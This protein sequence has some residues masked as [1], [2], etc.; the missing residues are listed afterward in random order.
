M[1]QGLLERSG[2]TPRRRA[3]FASGGVLLLLLALWQL[4]GYWLDGHLRADLRA[5]VDL[6]AEARVA[7][8]ESVLRQ[9][10][11]LLDGLAA[12]TAHTPKDDRFKSA[13]EGFSSNLQRNDPVILAFSLIPREGRGYRWE[14][15]GAGLPAASP[16]PPPVPGLPT[17]GL[18]RLGSVLDAGAGRLVVEIILPIYDRDLF[19]GRATVLLALSPLLREAG[20]ETVDPE[21]EWALLK[22]PQRLLGGLSTLLERNPRYFSVNL[23]GSDWRL[24]VEPRDGWEAA[25]TTPLR[26]YGAGGLMLVVLLTVLFHLL[27]GRQAWLAESVHQSTEVLTR[28]SRNLQRETRGRLHLEEQLRLFRDLVD[29]SPDAF[30]IIEPAT[31]GVV[32][33]NRSGCRLFE[34]S[35]DLLVGAPFP[36]LVNLGGGTEGWSDLVTAV[37]TEP[38]KRLPGEIRLRD[39]SRRPVDIAL[40][41]VNRGS[42]RHL[43]A[44]VR[45]VSERTRTEQSLRENESRL[46]RIVEEMPVMLNAF[47]EQGR[48]LFWNRA[49]ERVS[50]YRAEEIVGNAEASA[51]LYPDPDYRRQMLAE[52]SRWG[53]NYRDREWRLTTRS[54]EVRH[55]LWSDI[56]AQVPIPGWPYWGVGVDITPLRHAEERLSLY[57]AIFSHSTDAVGIIA[58][59]G[60]YLRQN[61][62]HRRLLGYEDE[63][64]HRNTPALHMGERNFNDIIHDLEHKGDFRGEVTC[65]RADGRRIEVEISAFPVLDETGR[66]FCYVGIKRDATERRRVEQRL[67]QA[68]TVF[69][70]TT[71]GVMI[72]DARQRIIMVNDA[73]TSITGYSRREVLGRTPDLLGSGH[74][75]QSF[76]DA[77]NAQLREQGQWRGEIWNRRRDGELYPAW[78]SIGTVPND[79]GGISNFVAVFSDISSI[80]ESERKFA[81]LAHHDALTGLPNRLL[82]HA[83]LE[84]AINEARRKGGRLAVFFMDLDRFKAINDT[85]GHAVGDSLLKEVA[86]RLSGCVRESDTV[87]RLGGDE[88]TLILTGL[89]RP[90]DAALVAH[91]IL[92]AMA[93]PFSLGGE[94]RQV[95]TSIGIAL[96]PRDAETQERLVECADHALYEAKAAGRNAFRFS[97]DG[98]GSTDRTG[99]PG[100]AAT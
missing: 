72:T 95:T 41:H 37:Q 94:A 9:R 54:G 98:G 77:M 3:W 43:V 88:F 45:D 12:F 80:K 1:Q 69:E 81:H 47:D 27:A 14:T 84:Q 68:A 44:V 4:G 32:E 22:P 58:T 42:E 56:S 28:T 2:H 6:Q 13:F 31:A 66:P 59:D 21:L 30:L 51:L 75:P 83:R 8:L 40:S 24:A 5:R 70:N 29:H 50:G 10:F 55:I 93:A 67:R 87:A 26:L 63:V 99:K 19:W 90:D 82:F 38:G 71:E 76:F 46:R 18:V 89:Q 64:L 100:P 35:R 91:K 11:R 33:V 34:R 25:V 16:R 96:Y 17:P 23:P 65:R 48:V 92:A 52:Q 20:F 15:P 79:A 85:L 61:A 62:A 73:F 86:T 53:H 49:C 36:D 97:N 78:L 39:G 7:Q 60:H 57:Q 74:H